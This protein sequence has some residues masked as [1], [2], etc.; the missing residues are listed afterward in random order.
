[1]R[2]IGHYQ[3]TSVFGLLNLVSKNVNDLGT[4]VGFSGSFW[5]VSGIRQLKRQAFSSIKHCHIN[6]VVNHRDY[7]RGTSKEHSTVPRSVFFWCNGADSTGRDIGDAQ[8]I[9]QWWRREVMEIS[10]SK[11]PKAT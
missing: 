3:C 7:L 11:T 8:E 6:F 9:S 10:R 2:Y 4:K 5:K 1:L